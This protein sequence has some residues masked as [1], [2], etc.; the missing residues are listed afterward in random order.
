MKISIRRLMVLTSIMIIITLTCSTL[1]VSGSSASEAV[2]KEASNIDA[3]MQILSS[4]GMFTGTILVAQKGNIVINKSYGMAN[5]ELG[6]PNTPDTKYRIGSLTKQFTA[7]LVMT[8]QE[9]GLLNV[10]D[11][12]SKYLPDYPNGGK[13]TLH[14]LLTHASGIPSFTSFP[15][16]FQ[17][18]CLPTTVEDLIGRFRDKPLEFEPGKGFSYSNS[19][20]CLLGYIIEK[21]TGKTYESCLN[22][23]IL[24]PL[25][26]KDT[27][28]DHHETVL[29]NRASGYTISNDTFVNADYISM[30]V[31]YSAGALYSTASDLYKWDR[32]LYTN[33]ILSNDSIKK[34][35]TPYN[36]T[37][38]YGWFI[39][40]VF[41]RKTV[42]HD[43]GV[44]GFSSMI[45]RYTDDD[46]CIILLGNNESG[47]GLSASRDI[48]AILL[49]EKYDLPKLHIEKKLSPEQLQNILGEYKDASGD[50]VFKVVLKDDRLYIDCP[51]DSTLYIHPL[52][53]TD[54][55][56]KAYDMKLTFVKGE[57]AQITGMNMNFYGQIINA[58][59]LNK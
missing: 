38:G 27:G 58:E 9:K 45:T 14:H 33:K 55:F 46:V 29:K 23:N 57:N 48:A 56:S 47:I 59:K 2:N 39:E 49:G 30:T 31:P 50:M 36:E 8:L 24:T 10:N 35:F 18:M 40:D 5:Y 26:M 7:A 34:I 22:E 28:Y 53:E 1:A 11:P 15:D 43:G 52:S 41:G 16:Y 20:Y 21:V 32:A 54:F 44:N 25:N 42:W 17:T 13:I 51:I 4:N 3:Y 37:Y 6:V 19:G 12:V